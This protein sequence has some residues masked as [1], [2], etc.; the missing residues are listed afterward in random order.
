MNFSCTWSNE[1]FD[2]TKTWATLREVQSAPASHQFQKHKPENASSYGIRH[3]PGLSGG[4]RRYFK[5]IVWDLD[6][7]LNVA[8]NILVALVATCAHCSSPYVGFTA[9]WDTPLLCAHQDPEIERKN[10]VTLSPFPLVELRFCSLSDYDITNIWAGIK[11]EPERVQINRWNNISVTAIHKRQK[12]SWQV[13]SWQK[14]SWIFNTS[15][16]N[17]A[18]P[19]GVKIECRKDTCIVN[20]YKNSCFRQNMPDASIIRKSWVTP[21]Y[22]YV[23]NIAHCYRSQLNFINTFLPVFLCYARSSLG[24]WGQWLVRGSAVQQRVV[25]R[26]MARSGVKGRRLLPCLPHEVMYLQQRWEPWRLEE[27]LT[28]PFLVLGFLWICTCRSY[29]ESDLD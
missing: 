9:L 19:T 26:R 29:W 21:T 11:N 4:W 7:S 10:P 14:F 22:K 17:A 18:S 28:L 16:K 2:L 24:Q 5:Y 25:S 13:K 8:P 15:S 12:N 6:A 23:D 27:P 3:F 20:L 1:V